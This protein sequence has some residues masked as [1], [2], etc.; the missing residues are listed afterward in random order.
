MKHNPLF[1]I[2]S[3]LVI[4]TTLITMTGCDKT[5]E[6]PPAE[7]ALTETPTPDAQATIDIVLTQTI[8]AE[9]EFQGAVNEAVEATITAMS[10]LDEENSSDMSEEEM[11]AEIDQAVNDAEN[12]S[13]QLSTATNE[14]AADGS[15]TQ[16]E[17]D[18]IEALVSDLA[19]AIALAEDLIYLYDD[20]YGELAIETLYLL[21]ELEDDLDELAAFATDMVE[22]LIIAEEALDEGLLV[23]EDVIA[24]FEQVVSQ[25]D[26]TGLTEAKNAWVEARQIE[27]EDRI[28]MITNMVPTEAAG[29]RREAVLSAFN[30][31]DTVRA[32]LEDGTFTLAELQSIGQLGANVQANFAQF[33]GPLLQNRSAEISSITSMLARGQLSQA[34][35]GL[36]QLESLLGKRP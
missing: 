24:Q 9:D 29:T 25:V 30:Y 15:I 3:L 20:V 32:A 1:N 5:T 10:A 16:E 11:A 2:I 31:V 14:A 21:T 28:E 6:P 17:A 22:L 23:A 12:A 34:L 13:E 19:Y 27:A 35:N 4:L 7:D 18:E 8:V 26:V 36:N 33:S